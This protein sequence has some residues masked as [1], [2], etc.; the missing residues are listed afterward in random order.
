MSK[1]LEK[2]DSFKRKRYTGGVSV[3]IIEEAEKT[4]SVTFA[5][6]YKDILTNYGFLFVKGE[7]F[8][9][10]DSNSYDIV[11][12]T[13]EARD[14]YVDF[15]T[16]MYVIENIAIDGILLI[17]DATGNIYFFQ[18]N[19]PLQKVKSSICEYLDTL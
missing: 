9:G 13:L 8:L 2:I 7:E 14:E 1:I 5:N 11:K 6:E 12:A 18:T 15:P 17:Q 19:S 16:G 10:L 4:L 3:D